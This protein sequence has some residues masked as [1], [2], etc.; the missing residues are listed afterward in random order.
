M[1][2]SSSGI[3]SGLDVEN[4]ITKLVALE[5]QPLTSLQIKAT[6]IQ[7]KI[8]DYSQVKALVSTL[9]DAASKLSLDSGWN[10]LSVVS[11]NSSALTDRSIL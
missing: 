2:I 10:S 5:K 11:S 1:G 6:I 4:I 8:S 7:T 9:T 3:G